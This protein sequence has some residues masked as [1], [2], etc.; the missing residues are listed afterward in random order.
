MQ[1]MA[2]ETAHDVKSSIGG[3]AVCLR[4]VRNALQLVRP[5]HGIVCA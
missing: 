1:E 2:Q 4:R 5:P 3:N